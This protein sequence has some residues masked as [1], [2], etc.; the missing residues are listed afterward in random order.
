MIEI[1]QGASVIVQEA[2]TLVLQGTRDRPIA[3]LADAGAD[4][5]LISVTGRAATLRA[6]HTFV[7]AATPASSS[8]R[9][10]H[11]PHAL[12]AVR[13]GGLMHLGETQLT[14]L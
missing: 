12:L 14:M 8:P 1:A 11:A 2:S 6:S 7:A 13:H 10:E 9:G 5:P 3:L 4:G